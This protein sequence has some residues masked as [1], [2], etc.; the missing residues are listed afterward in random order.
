M[1][2]G[3][4]GSEGAKFTAVTEAAARVFISTL[5]ADAA[6]IV[7]GECHL[8]GVD[9]FAR[10]EAERAGVPFK[11]YPPRRLV[12]DGGY[13]QRNLQIAEASD[14]VYCITLRELPETYEG[15]RFNVCYHCRLQDHVKSGGYWTVKQAVAQG[16]E[17]R[18]VIIDPTGNLVDRA[19]Q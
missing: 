14:R 8:G 19:W 9:I 4:V 10:Q 17:G 12:W 15:M 6:L 1:K 3:I 16:K 13:K 2:I 18:I 11:G 5:L 7:S